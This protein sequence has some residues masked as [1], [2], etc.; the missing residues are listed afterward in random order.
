MRS[1]LETIKNTYNLPNGEYKGLCS[2]YEVEV[3]DQQGK[4]YRLRL[5]NRVHG[6]DVPVTVE[7]EN[8]LIDIY[9]GL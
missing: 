4:T 9:L 3:T 5:T 8:K 1:F 6:I 2:G 7:V